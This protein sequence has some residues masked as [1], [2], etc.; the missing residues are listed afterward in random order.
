MSDAQFSP[1]V[2]LRRSAE[3]KAVLARGRRHSDACFTVVC[4]P[5]KSGPTRL[6]LVV[7]R[8]VSRL[9]VQRNRIKRQIR[10]SFRQHRKHMPAMDMVV[11]ARARAAAS[12]N[13]TLAT[14]LGQHWQR[15]QC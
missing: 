4:L 6:G 14:S 5:R 1:R 15:L 2:R 11:M 9:A 13:Q 3:F 7:S 12:S 10:E 8:R